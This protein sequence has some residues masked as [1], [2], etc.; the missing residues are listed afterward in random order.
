MIGCDTNILVRAAL[1]D[2]PREAKIA[3]QL[4]TKL[5]AEKKLFIASYAI[6]EM[7][8]VLKIKKRTRH[9]ICEAVLTLLDSVG[10]TVSQREIVTTALEMYSNGKADF[11]DYLIL[12]EGQFNGAASLASFDKDLCK[13]NHHAKHP[14]KYL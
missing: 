5:A 12:A 9:E 1:D 2:N 4:L 11:G 13:D 7:V 3:K 8:W 10:V 6:L 14:K